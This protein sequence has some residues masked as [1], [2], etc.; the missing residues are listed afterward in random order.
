[1]IE[2]AVIVVGASAVTVVV[3]VL[4]CCKTSGECARVEERL[5]TKDKL[6]DKPVFETKGDQT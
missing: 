6:T 4:A 5:D 3:T 2:V 1:M